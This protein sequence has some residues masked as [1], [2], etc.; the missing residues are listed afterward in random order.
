MARRAQEM[1]EEMPLRMWLLQAVGGVTPEVLRG[2]LECLNG[3]LIQGI[4]VIL[5]AIRNRPS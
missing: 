1:L 5:Q 4:R 2:L 3:R